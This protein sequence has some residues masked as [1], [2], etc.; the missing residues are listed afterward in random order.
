MSAPTGLLFKRRLPYRVSASSST[1]LTSAAAERPPSLGVNIRTPRRNPRRAVLAPFASKEKKIPT[2]PGGPGRYAGTVFRRG[3]SSAH[4]CAPDGK[5]PCRGPC[6]HCRGWSGLNWSRCACVQRRDG[7][8]LTGGQARYGPAWSTGSPGNHPDRRQ[9]GNRP[10][11]TG[12][13]PGLCPG[14]CTF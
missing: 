13:P 4:T 11:E 6:F 10:V 2:E 3:D 9:L 5:P 12:G 14:T 7:L 1:T 8:P